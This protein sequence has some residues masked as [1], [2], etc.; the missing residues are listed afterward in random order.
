MIAA[1]GNDEMLLTVARA[2][3]AVALRA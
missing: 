3:E 1:R 2:L